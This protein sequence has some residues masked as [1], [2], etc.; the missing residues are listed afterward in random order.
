MAVRMLLVADL[1]VSLGCSV[2]CS[3]QHCSSSLT[4]A[5]DSLSP[6]RDTADEWKAEGADECCGGEW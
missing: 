5:S 6:V 4:S 1:S 2:Q 3:L